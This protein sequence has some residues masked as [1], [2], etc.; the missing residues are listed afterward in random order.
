MLLKIL[1]V[2]VCTLIVSLVLKQYKPELS[3]LVS[4][5]GGLIIFMLALDSASNLVSEF[6]TLEEM[7]GQNVNIVKPIM[8]VLGVGYITE[9]TA[10]LAEDSGN[11]SIAS[12]IVLGGKIAI[13]ALALPLIKEL[14]NA[15]I[16]II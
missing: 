1:G 12:K 13:C 10:S 2:G 15:I 3:V 7:V 4:I 11:K 8:K 5:C 16:S 14:V 9:F 6:Y